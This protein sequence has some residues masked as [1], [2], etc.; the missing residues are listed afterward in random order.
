[1]PITHSFS[2]YNFLNELATVLETLTY[3]LQAAAILLICSGRRSAKSMVILPF[4]GF[5]LYP[6][7]YR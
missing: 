3:Y 1:M 6:F 2:V 5:S 7:R 4:T